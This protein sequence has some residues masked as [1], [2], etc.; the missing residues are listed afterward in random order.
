MIDRQSCFRKMTDGVLV[1]VRLT[2][3][4]AKDAVEGV[5]LAADLHAHLKV[6]VRAVPEDGKANAALEKLLAKELGVATG[7]VALVAGA[8]SRLKQIKILGD[9][10]ALAPKLEAL[11]SPKA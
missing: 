8:T 4:S 5:A 6:R 10:H 3:K 2:P 7:E 11:G 9:P 1:F